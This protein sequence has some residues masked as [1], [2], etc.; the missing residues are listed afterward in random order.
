M[1]KCDQKIS[2]ISIQF[3]S[4]ESYKNISN[5]LGNI[6]LKTRGIFSSYYS[7]YE[8]ASIYSW[9]NYD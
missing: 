9:D 4:H 6:V 5:L 2:L 7:W 1:A 3:S 8:S